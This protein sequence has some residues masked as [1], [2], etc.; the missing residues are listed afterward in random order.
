MAK[1]N[2]LPPPQRSEV[3]TWPAEIA[4]SQSA[5][6][7][8]QQLKPAMFSNFLYQVIDPTTGDIYAWLESVPD[9]IHAGLEAALQMQGFKLVVAREA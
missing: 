8:T 5:K 3:F 6:P 2:I 7:L 9:D 1:E 4:L